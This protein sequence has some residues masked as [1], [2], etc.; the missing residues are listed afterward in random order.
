MTTK[1][2][3]QLFI[4]AIMACCIAAIMVITIYEVQDMFIS[5]PAYIS[6]VRFPM[7]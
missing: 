4:L 6:R 1:L 7:P 2:I 3:Y 5:V